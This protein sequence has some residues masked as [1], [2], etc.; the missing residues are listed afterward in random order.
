MSKKI[1]IAFVLPSLV[2]GG[3]ERVMSFI[4]NN[5]SKEHFDT[6]LW[7][8][9]VPEDTVYNVDSIKVKYFNK[10][11][12]LNAI[13]SFFWSLQKEKPDL[14]VS[15]LCY[16]NTAMGLLSIFFPKI[17]FIGR[18]ANVHNVSTNEEKTKGTKR[19]GAYVPINF[20]YRFLDKIICQSNDMYN[21]MK[22][23]YGIP[24]SKLKTINNPITDNFKLEKRLTDKGDC[25]Q[26]ITVGRLS[27]QKGHK[28]IISVLAKLDIPFKYT[29]IGDGPL[30][31]DIFEL[32]KELGLSEKIIHIPYTN[33]ISKYLS[34][35]D[36]F[37]QGSYFEGFPNCLLESSAMGT[38]IVGYLAPGGI[39]EIIENG[40]NG[41]I[42]EDEEQYADYILK[43]VNGH[44]WNPEIINK[45]VTDKF[46]K[47][48]ILKEYESLFIEV[49]N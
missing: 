38:P 37:L 14:V 1:K 41:F 30:K 17:K 21:D 48:K 9:G 36:L 20:G 7:I 46:N 25:F 29:I 26:F 8:A 49:L 16:L 34:K 27:K 12:V 5:I 2:A 6:T 35:S 13:P 31:E 43:S 47:H 3:A 42:A 32:I 11:R 44:Q 40:V 10:S 19:I 45:T 24:D 15:S 4:A 28:R 22:L 39:D 23:N 33:E 18:E